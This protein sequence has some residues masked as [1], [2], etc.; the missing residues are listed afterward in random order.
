MPTAD[1]FDLF[2]LAHSITIAVIVGVACLLVFFARHPRFTQWTPTI[3]AILA[4]VLLS[5]EVIWWIISY[6]VGLWRLPLQLC[7]LVL[8]AVVFSLLKHNPFIW[9]LAY[10]WGLAGT[11]QAVLTPDIRFNFPHYYFFKFFITHGGV[12]TAIVFLAAGCGKTIQ[13]T[14][15]W[16]VFAVTNAYA[17]L[18]GIFN[19]FFKTNYLYLCQKP[20]QPSLLDYLGPWPFYILSLEVVLIVQLY[21]YYLP[22]WLAKK[23]SQS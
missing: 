21:F 7:D 4:I 19:F 23:T 5:N 20:V 1:R 18:I 12:V 10:F 22:F 15:I 6:F 16:R 17:F 8:F 13:H 11:L 9:E 14:A 2:G 3:R